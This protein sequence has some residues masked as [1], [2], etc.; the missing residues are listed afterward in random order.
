MIKLP[1]HFSRIDTVLHC[2]G[3]NLAFIA[4]KYGTPTYVYSATA[5][6]EAYQVYA[7]ALQGRKTR[8][9]YALKANSNLSVLQLLY[10]LGAG[11]DIVSIGE[12]EAVLAIGAKGADVVFSGVGKSI[13]EM[14]RA[15]SAD[16]S[17]FNIESIPELD[18]L[19]TV[20]S[21]M[22]KMATIS[23]RVNPDVDPK[24]H[25]YISTGLKENKFG[26]A[27][28]AALDLYRYAS[29]LSH[30]NIAGID[31]HIGSQITTVAPYLDALDRLLDVVESIE[32]SGI[33]IRHLD[34]GG[35]IGIDYALDGAVNVPCVGEFISALLVK[36]DSRSHGHRT[37]MF[38]PGRSI[39]GNA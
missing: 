34:L 22:R 30:I 13:S 33:A 29:R 37:L 15:L 2:E 1:P 6:T 24:T 5:I 18:R 10:R 25:P 26:V 3:V 31:C 38:E 27:K 23:I 16:V 39:I 8:I 9:H 17:C 4:K 32:A 12:L 7:T 28:E 14:Q 35:G 21:G 11:F 19:N 20:A 36:L